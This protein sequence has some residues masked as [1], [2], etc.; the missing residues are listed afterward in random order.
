MD[1]PPPA[2]APD[3]PD[4]DPGRRG[5]RAAPVIPIA[6][7]PRTEHRIGSRRLVVTGLADDHLVAAARLHRSC[8]MELAGELLLPDHEPP[9]GHWA[10]VWSAAVDHPRRFALAA[11]LD[12][13]LV[14]AATGD[15]AGTLEHFLVDTCARGTG[16]ADLLADAVH[17]Q[18][19]PSTSSWA[20]QRLVGDTASLR[21]WGRRGWSLAGRHRARLAHGRGRSPDG[22][23]LLARLRHPSAYVG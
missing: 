9:S 12:D 10:T 18:L 15:P 13:R 17:L 2:R 19:A 21:F 14:A 7:P 23:V 22:R 4:G 16:V 8:R 3:V 1:H 6:Q 20:L 5:D 11:L